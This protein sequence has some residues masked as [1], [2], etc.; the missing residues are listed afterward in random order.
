[1]YFN[2]DAQSRIVSRWHF[3]LRDGGYLVLGK[4]EMLVNFTTV[5]EALDIKRRVFR[6]VR[7]TTPTR[8]HILGYPA[9]EERPMAASVPNRLREIAFDQ[10]PITQL[11]V[12]AR[13][14]LVLANTR[15]RDLF[16]LTSRDIGRP[17][18]DLEL[19][20]RPVELRSCID[21]AHTRRQSV[22]VREVAWP[23]NTGDGRFSTCR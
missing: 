22:Q 13:G 21:D 9:R 20:Y 2:Q 1:M 8:E 10:D 14:V 15:A 19:S 11:V 12:D 18:Q 7:G 6:K 16:G 4:A 5:F 17:L 23:T 3:A